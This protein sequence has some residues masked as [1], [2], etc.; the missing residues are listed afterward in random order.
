LRFV[1]HNKITLFSYDLFRFHFTQILLVLV[2]YNEHHNEF[3]GTNKKHK[4]S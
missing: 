2:G 4:T 3:F 1:A